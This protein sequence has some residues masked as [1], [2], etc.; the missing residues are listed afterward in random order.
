MAKTVTS[1]PSELLG[2]ESGSYIAYCLDE[3]VIAWGNYVS[4]QLEKIE[5][6][7]PKQVERKRERRLIELL[8]I[9]EPEKVR[10]KV[11]KFADPSEFFS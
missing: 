5:G 11:T 7:N 4:H 9:N 6:K 2:L 3:A 8:S 10:K 1:R